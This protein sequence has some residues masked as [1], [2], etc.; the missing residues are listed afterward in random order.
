MS[1]TIT[2]LTNLPQLRLLRD[3][4]VEVIA[5]HPFEEIAISARMQWAGPDEA[6]GRGFWIRI[7]AD[8]SSDGVSVSFT[9]DVP[10]SL[11]DPG[12][13]CPAW[14]GD[15]RAE[16]ILSAWENMLALRPLTSEMSPSVEIFERFPDDEA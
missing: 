8:V 16:Y 12:L 3:Y 1:A 7:N 9:T 5:S 6:G 14:M 13:E 15:D 10:V 2:D 11:D 4:I